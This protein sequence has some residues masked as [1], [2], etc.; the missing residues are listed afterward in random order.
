MLGL[1][2]PGQD[3][4]LYHISQQQ[5]RDKQLPGAEFPPKAN[6]LIR[7]RR[8]LRLRGAQKALGGDLDFSSP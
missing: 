8:D 3:L 6:V 7:S 2:A 1:V 4:S 5:R